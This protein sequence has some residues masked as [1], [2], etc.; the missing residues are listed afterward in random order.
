MRKKPLRIVM[1]VAE[2]LKH[3]HSR[4]LIHRDIKPENIILTK[5]VG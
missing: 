3:A 5:E 4:G 1:A 2:A